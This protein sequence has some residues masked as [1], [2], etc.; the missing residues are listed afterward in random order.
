MWIKCFVSKKLVLNRNIYNICNVVRTMKAIQ[1][2]S[3]ISI[4][5]E[6]DQVNQA[7]NKNKEISK[8]IGILLLINKG[9]ACGWPLDWDW[10]HWSSIMQSL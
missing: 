2:T 6:W 3:N 5:I 9:L 10:A 7:F 8:I 4:Y 1:I